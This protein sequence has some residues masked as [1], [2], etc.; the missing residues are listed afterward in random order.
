MNSANGKISDPHRLF[1][2]LLDK[3]NLKRTDV[4]FYQIFAYTV[5]GRI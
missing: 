5:H 4:L 3:I 1:L 2:N